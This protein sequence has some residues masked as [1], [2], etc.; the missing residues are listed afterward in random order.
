MVGIWAPRRVSTGT[1]LRVALLLLGDGQ[2]A[3]SSLCL[4]YQHS[5]EKAHLVTARLGRGSE[6]LCV[7]TD[8]AGE[9]GPSTGQPG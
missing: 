4:F 8:S 2:S 3:D 7:S 9:E 6:S 1:V 5:S